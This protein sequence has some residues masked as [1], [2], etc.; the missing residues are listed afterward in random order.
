MALHCTAN[1]TTEIRAN[2]TERQ[3]ARKK[4]VSKL[5]KIKRKRKPRNSVISYLAEA[6]GM[7]SS[8][9]LLA[10]IGAI[11]RDHSD[12]HGGWLGCLETSL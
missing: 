8:R 7:L 4:K 12:T 3:R 11:R 9:R 1:K 2:E 5:L 6:P 10:L